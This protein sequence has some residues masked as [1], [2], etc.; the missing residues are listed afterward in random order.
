MRSYTVAVASLVIEAPVKWTDNLISQHSLPEVVS[1]CRGVARRISHPALVRLALIRQLHIGLGIGV[2]GAVQ[3][4]ASLL[5]PDGA[6]ALGSGAIR[7][8]FDH[9]A[10]EG[11]I[12]A[13]LAEVLESAPTP[14]RGRPPR[15]Q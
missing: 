4:A 8:T 11:E 5:D 3:I 15:K 10:L 6:A 1:Q 14:R 7:L 9:R 2:A 12:Q 13:R